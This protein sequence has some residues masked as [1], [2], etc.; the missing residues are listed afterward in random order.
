M[1]NRHIGISLALTT[2]ATALTGCATS[3]YRGPDLTIDQYGPVP[4]KVDKVHQVSDVPL[5]VLF[6]AAETSSR[7]NPSD[8]ALAKKMLQAALPVINDR[9]DGFLAQLEKDG[10][11]LGATRKATNFVGAFAG[12]VLALA[13]VSKGVLAGTVLATNSVGAANDT[14]LAELTSGAADTDA[15]RIMVQGN[16]ND[17]ETGL[18]KRDMS[19][20]TYASTTQDIRDAQTICQAGTIESNV[21]KAIASG[22]FAA[23]PIGTPTATQTT[24]KPATTTPPTATQKTDKPATTTPSTSTTPAPADQSTAKTGKTVLMNLQAKG[25]IT[26][27]SAFSEVIKNLDDVSSGTPVTTTST[28]ASTDNAGSTGP[29]PATPAQQLPPIRLQLV[30]Q[31]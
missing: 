18:L 5:Y 1:G 29:T 6:K 25:L 8:A 15:I 21:K 23:L 17:F 24:D 31:Q 2:A 3:S 19:G 7:G 12:S 16:L 20:A 11:N 14:L 26:N 13:P 27:P 9:C 22:K 4:P 30:P 28:P 10:R